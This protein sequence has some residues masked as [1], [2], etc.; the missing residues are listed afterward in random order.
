MRKK[1]KKETQCEDYEAILRSC[2][3]T[4]ANEKEYGL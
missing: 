3:I 1:I 4:L 2:K